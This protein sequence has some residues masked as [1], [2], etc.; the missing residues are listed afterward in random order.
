MFGFGGGAETYS[1][2]Y[3]MALGKKWGINAEAGHLIDKGFKVRITGNGSY[4]MDLGSDIAGIE[5][6]RDKLTRSIK[7]HLG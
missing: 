4:T 5:K 2:A 7:K 1:K 6:E 3:L